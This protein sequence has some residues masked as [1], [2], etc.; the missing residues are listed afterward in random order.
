MGGL[1]GAVVVDPHVGGGAT[2][3]VGGLPRDPVTRVGLV[4]A[5]L[6][7]QP[8]YPGLGVGADDDGQVL[9]RPEPAFDE[10]RHV[11]DRDRLGVRGGPLLAAPAP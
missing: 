4:Q 10:Q 2:L 7:D 3:L 5:A 11:V 1:D 8:A 9:V 6:L